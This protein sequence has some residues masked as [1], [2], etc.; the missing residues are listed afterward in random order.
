MIDEE[1][2]AEDEIESAEDEAKARAGELTF[3]EG[4]VLGSM[5]EKQATTPGQYP[6]SLNLIQTACN[7]RSSRDPVA[8]FDEETVERALDGL[9][10]K[11]LAVKVHLSG[12]RVPKY[13]HTTDRVLTI[14]QD[15]QAL[16]CILLLRGVQ[17]AGEL[18]QRSERIH[19]F[20]SVEAVEQSLQ[21]LID[22]PAF[23]I[24]KRFPSGSGR[25]AVI[26]AHLLSGE[27][28]GLSAVPAAAGGSAVSAAQIVLEEESSWR[29]K[30]EGQVAELN[31]EL[32]TLRS[33]FA[34]FR[35]QFD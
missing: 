13:R 3:A 17:T 31:S 21:S 30:L 16:I 8:D 10:D 1:E 22:F 2:D 12:S 19:R 26:Y 4:R 27:P 9:R 34:E 15:Q 25:R 6:M 23:P 18:N 7:Q 20:G 28:E 24:V 33:E 32:E 14:T 11:K 29:K 5:L 35:R